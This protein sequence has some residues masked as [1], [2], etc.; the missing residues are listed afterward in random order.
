M[1]K[2]NN[3][4]NKVH[5]VNGRQVWESRSVAV[6]C[7]VVINTK[8]EPYV[9]ISQRGK[10]APDSVGLFNVPS[11]YLD[12]NESGTE[13]VYREVW[14]E[15]GLYLLEQKIIVNNLLNPW[16]V[17]THPDENRQN[18]SLRYG[19]VIGLVGNEFPILTS[20][21]SE[22]DEVADIKWAPVSELGQYKFAF[23]HDV[24]IK[25]YLNLIGK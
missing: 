20:E 19:C 16:Y 9:L 24:V 25:Q 5:L 2:F 11:G 8:N 6:N 1:K 22:P 7:V 15:T 4:P 12:Y 3:V 13:A 23:G 10:G 17:N 18:V 14:E 21:N